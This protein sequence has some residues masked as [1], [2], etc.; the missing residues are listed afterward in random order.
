MIL[1]KQQNKTTGHIKWYVVIKGDII[2]ITQKDMNYIY[3]MVQVDY[4]TNPA[5]IGNALCTN[6]FC[7]PLEWC[8]DS[9]ETFIN[10]INIDNIKII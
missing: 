3:S 9:V 4:R 10:K 5:T 8:V 6:I 7:H 1:M 2:E